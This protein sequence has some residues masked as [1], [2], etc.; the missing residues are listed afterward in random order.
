MAVDKGT[1]AAKAS[2]ISTKPSVSSLTIATLFTDLVIGCSSRL[3]FKP[4]ADLDGDLELFDFGV[5][6]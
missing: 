2:D 1:G 5:F 4:K 3:V 6:N